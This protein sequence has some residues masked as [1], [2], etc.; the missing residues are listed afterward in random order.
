MRPVTAW[1]GGTL[2]D[3][4]QRHLRRARGGRQPN[5]E[6][7]EHC[8]LALL[9][10]KGALDDGQAWQVGHKVHRDAASGRG[11]VD[12]GWRPHSG[13]G[14]RLEL[15]GTMRRSAATVFSKLAAARIFYYTSLGRDWEPAQVCL[16]CEFQHWCEVP[17]G[18]L[19]THSG[20]WK[21]LH[22]AGDAFI[23]FGNRITC[24]LGPLATESS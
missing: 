5:R 11:Q 13:P 19:S 18:H 21:V 7:S 20:K 4:A 15:E 8:V 12:S 17:C 22:R 3:S 2:E 23:K 1:Y 9:Q 16:V 24:M 14:G 10:P 6:H